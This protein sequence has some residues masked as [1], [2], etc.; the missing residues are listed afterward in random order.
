LRNYGIESGRILNLSCVL[1]SVLE[2]MLLSAPSKNLFQQTARGIPGWTPIQLT[3][4][5]V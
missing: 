3:I 2:S 5:L 4:V 1:G